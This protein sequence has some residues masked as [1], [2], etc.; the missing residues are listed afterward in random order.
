MKT[1]E[2]ILLGGVYTLLITPDLTGSLNVIN[3]IYLY[4]KT[5]TRIKLISM[6]TGITM[7]AI[8]I[9]ALIYV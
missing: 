2:D 3:L 5:R 4:L 7:K 9:M 1:Q 6:Y 8:D